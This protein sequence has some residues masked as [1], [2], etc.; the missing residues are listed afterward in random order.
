IAVNP[1]GPSKAA[2]RSDEALNGARQHEQIGLAV[3]R[4]LVEDFLRRDRRPRPIEPCI[5]LILRMPSASV[6]GF[7]LGLHDV[8][9]ATAK[10]RLRIKLPLWM[11]MVVRPQ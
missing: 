8:A 7:E 1:R 2:L 9:L 6:L 3:R 4:E 5:P 11:L 10:Q